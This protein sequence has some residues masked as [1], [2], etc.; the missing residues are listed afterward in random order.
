MTLKEVINQQGKYVCSILIKLETPFQIF[1]NKTSDAALHLVLDCENGCRLADQKN[2]WLV[3]FSHQTY[4]IIANFVLFEFSISHFFY[5]LRF[6]FAIWNKYPLY[7]QAW[8]LKNKTHILKHA[9][10]SLIRR[11]RKTNQSFLLH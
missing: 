4:N 9:I 5:F 6:H 2:N 10:F 11:K 8:C 1:G 7:I 3:F